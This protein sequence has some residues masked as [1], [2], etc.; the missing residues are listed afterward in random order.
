MIRIV[1][2]KEL[3]S[4]VQNLP[5]HIPIFVYSYVITEPWTSL[6][7]RFKYSSIFVSLE[8]I[9]TST[10][11]LQRIKDKT[12]IYVTRD[13]HLKGIYIPNYDILIIGSGNFTKRSLTRNIDLYIYIEGL[14]KREKR[15]LLNVINYIYEKSE[16]FKGNECK[17]DMG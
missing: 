5:P 4:I 1:S 12:N 11:S 6:F 8:K 14:P 3:F 9:C 16:T 15:K 10:V 7:S 13:L 2:P 17:K